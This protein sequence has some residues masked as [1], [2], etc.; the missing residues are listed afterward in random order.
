MGSDAERV[1]RRSS[2]PRPTRARRRRGELKRRAP[3]ETIRVRAVIAEI[4][5]LACATTVFV[6]A[7][8]EAP[9]EAGA[10][11]AAAVVPA[12]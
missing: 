2:G 12:R 1:L 7:A 5:A 6:A 9:V 8:L 4:L 3:C 11:V 10:D